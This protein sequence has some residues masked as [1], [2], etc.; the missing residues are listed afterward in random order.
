MK[1]GTIRSHTP[2]KIALEVV[3]KVKPLGGKYKVSIPQGVAD[4]MTVAE[5]INVSLVQANTD[6]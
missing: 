6:Q 2:D 4:K 1:N 3:D 5:K